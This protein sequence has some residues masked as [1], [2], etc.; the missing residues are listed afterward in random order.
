MTLKNR[1]MV[2]LNYSKI[3]KENIVTLKEKASSK[4]FQ[5]ENEEI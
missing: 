3:V 4:N 1:C 5:L 2:N